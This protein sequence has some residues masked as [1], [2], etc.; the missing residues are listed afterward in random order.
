MTKKERKACPSSTKKTRQD[1]SKTDTNIWICKEK[2]VGRIVGTQ[3]LAGTD[4]RIVEYRGKYGVPEVDVADGLDQDR[5][6]FTRLLE[7]NAELLDNYPCTVMVTVQGQRRKMRI[8]SFENTRRAIMM[9]DH[10]VKDPARKEFL[11]QRKRKYFQI[12]D[13]VLSGTNQKSEIDI[14][15]DEIGYNYKRRQF[16][17]RVRETVFIA[18]NRDMHPNSP[19]TFNKLNAMRRNDYFLHYGNRDLKPKWRK[20]LNEQ[21]SKSEIVHEIFSTCAITNGK[22]SVDEQMAFEKKL[23]EMVSPELRPEFFPVAIET[24]VQLKL[25]SG[26]IGA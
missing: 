13:D 3:S 26:D 17:N 22:L 7:R 14:D 9:V 4:V 18:I 12:L 5:G 25:T 8:L 10:N 6:N 2:N 15:F 1:I 19:D 16:R 24:T 11:I 23:F 21:Q 20:D